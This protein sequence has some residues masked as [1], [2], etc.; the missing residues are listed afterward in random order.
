MNHK[1][2]YRGLFVATILALAGMFIVDSQAQDAEPVMPV[3]I[4]GRDEAHRADVTLQ[5]GIRRLETSSVVTVQST[6]G[7]HP[8]GSTFFFFGATIEDANGIGAA[9][10][11]VRLE[12]PAAVSPIGTTLYP[13]VDI[14]YTITAGDVAANNPELEVADNFCDLANLDS[15]FIAANWKCEVARDMGYIHIQSR[16]FNEWGERTSYTITCSGTTSCN[17]G[18]TDIAIRS[19]AAE[20][21]PSPN[22]PAR[23]GF[24]GITGTVLTIPGGLGKRFFEFFTNTDTVPTDDMRQDCDAGSFSAAVCEFFVPVDND[25]DVFLSQIRCFGGCNGIKFGQHLCKN[26]DLANGVKFE[27]KSD[28]EV[29]TL[30]SIK[31]T[32]DWKNFF[33]FPLPGAAF[34][35][36]VQAG[37]DQFVATFQPELAFVVRKAGT[38][39]AGNDDFVKIIINDDLTGSPGGNLAEL[40]CIAEGFREE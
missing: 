5:A 38:F 33:S 22:D 35:I 16:L 31:A 12:I 15:N 17:Q 7:L 25:E 26:S 28:N 18:F 36:D 13:A 37:G 4:Q 1:T 3:V 24:F 21:A 6:F 19:K 20:L 14:T 40:R 9:N 32:E 8:Q 29:T 30:P 27:I 34:R 11:T 10:D 39:G 23:L 2:L